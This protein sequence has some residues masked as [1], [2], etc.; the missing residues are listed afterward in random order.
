MLLVF[1]QL[2]LLTGCDVDEYLSGYF[3][4]NE[5]TEKPPVST[6]AVYNT[7]GTE[8]T[9]T[10][11]VVDVMED[12]DNSSSLVSA[13]DLVSSNERLFEDFSDGYAYSQLGD[14]EK[15]VYKEI[16]AILMGLEEDVVLSTI[17]ADDVARCFKCVLVDNPDIFY[18]TGYSISKYML[19]DAIDK[20][21]F[22]GAYTMDADQVKEKR[23]VIEQ[24]VSNCLAGISQNASDYDKVKYVY[25]YLID[26]N[27]Y[28][29]DS[30]NNQNILSVCENQVTVCQGYA[31][32]TQLLLGR[33]GIFCT[34]VNGKAVNN[35]QVGADG[36]I[37]ETDTDEWGAHVWN[38]VCADGKYYNV[39]TTWGDSSFLLNTESGE[40]V[41]GPDI[42]YDYLMVPDSM[43]LDTHLPE[44]IVAMPTCSS[45]DD[46]YYVREGLYFTDINKDQLKAIFKDAYA[47]GY[48]CVTFK[49]SDEMIFDKMR[50]HLFGNEKIFDYLSGSSVKY[51]EYPQRCVWTVYL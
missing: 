32:M 26:D 34:L 1:T 14:K 37:Y 29:L 25:D 41:G 7:D 36:T 46:N 13:A 3:D 30:E 15:V 42:N 17:N 19:N 40:V 43:I 49:C 8:I 38:I 51:V 48:D 23:Q 31:K 47:N 50:D 33:L 4:S 16:Y 18:V 44:P 35:S 39:D 45:M 21:T 28:E 10:E 22:K 9:A 11:S 12:E 24:Y 20:I 27:T 5:E 2:I 6:I